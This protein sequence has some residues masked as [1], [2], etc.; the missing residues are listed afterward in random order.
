MLTVKDTMQRDAFNNNEFQLGHAAMFA[1]EGLPDS[2]AKQLKKQYDFS[3]MTVGILGMALER[4]ATISG[5]HF[6]IR[7]TKIFEL[8]AGKVPCSDSYVPDE[9]H[10][11]EQTLITESEII[12]ISGSHRRHENL[13]IRNKKT[14][15]KCTE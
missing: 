10:V 11:D 4:K 3:R 13:S 8:E 2:V 9:S 5:N 7:Q 6:R 15:Y 1:N 12:I 14:V